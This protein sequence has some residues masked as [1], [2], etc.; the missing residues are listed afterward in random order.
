MLYGGTWKT[1]LEKWW[2]APLPCTEKDTHLPLNPRETCLYWRLKPQREARKLG[3]RKCLFV[4][5]PSVMRAPR[6]KEEQSAN[7][8][9]NWLPMSLPMSL[10]N[11]LLY[12]PPNPLPNSPLTS[13]FKTPPCWRKI[14]LTTT[15]LCISSVTVYRD[16]TNCCNLLSNSRPM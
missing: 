10:P 13:L 16:N 7:S 9:S 15:L 4:P 1:H 5:I 14:H 8:L 11:S 3:Q 2:R 6:P 12:L